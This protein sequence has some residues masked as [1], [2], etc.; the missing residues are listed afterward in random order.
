MKARAV[1]ALSVR[2]TGP[3]P[4]HTGGDELQSGCWCN[5]MGAPGSPVSRSGGYLRLTDSY[6]C[7]SCPLTSAW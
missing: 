3:G 2:P 1:E 5:R 6:T 4:R 7:H